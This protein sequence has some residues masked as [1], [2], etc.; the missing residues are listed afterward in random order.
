MPWNVFA[1][2]SAKRSTCD[3]AVS[4]PQQPIAGN[5]ERRAHL[6]AVHATSRQFD[7]FV[8][9]ALQQQ[10]QKSTLGKSLI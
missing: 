8:A 7:H 1:K 6:L 2:A 3:D 10:G 4:T 9:L 5:L